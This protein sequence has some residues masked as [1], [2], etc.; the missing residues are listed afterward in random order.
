MKT[1]KIL[2]IAVVLLFTTVGLVSALQPPSWIGAKSV[3]EANCV[4]K[5]VIMDSQGNMYFTGFFGPGDITFG[6]ITLHNNDFDGN[7]F[8]AKM[9][10]GGTW[11]WATSAG[12]GLD[13]SGDDIAMDS[14]GNIYIVGACE[15]LTSTFGTHTY[16]IPYGQS[17][18][19]KLTPGGTWSRVTFGG[20]LWDGEATDD[21]SVQSIALDSNKNVYVTG[22]FCG[23]ANFGSTTLD[24]GPVDEVYRMVYVGKLN[25]SGTWLWAQKAGGSE[26][27]DAS[28]GLG[29]AADSSGSPYITGYYTGAGQ[30]GSISLP[31]SGG[32]DMFT[33]KLNTN[34]AWLWARH[35]GGQGNDEGRSIALDS[36]S[37][38]YVTGFFHGT[39]Q[40]GN[41]VLQ[42]HGGADAFVLKSNPSGSM[43]WVRG[44][45]NSGTDDIGYGIALDSSG[46][47]YV[48]GPIGPG[49]FIMKTSTSGSQQWVATAMSQ[50]GF[51]VANS[52]AMNSQKKPVITGYF[53]G[54]I[55]FGA[56]I[57]VSPEMVFSIFIA[58]L[59]N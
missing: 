19:A 52:I 15:S 11:L 47:A 28:E 45:G 10:P 56:K 53:T 55:H 49:V 23:I 4:S 38:A 36:N 26:L 32:E 13:D 5:A 43:Q 21:L 3:G 31:N 30:F 16:S 34:G 42:S 1:P 29:I 59:G 27:H 50:N 22:S 39:A 9:S 6:S 35:A 2:A 46:N 51:G 57:L 18:I 25:P 37:N 41:T 33:A 54:N 40:F 48:T 7:V 17:F 20:R 24:A 44:A 8:V 14:S 12:G 58:K